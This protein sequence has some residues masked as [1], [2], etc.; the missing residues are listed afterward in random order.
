MKIEHKTRAGVPV[1][2]CTL[3]QV[4][5]A[6]DF[7]SC[8]RDVGVELKIVGAERGRPFDKVPHFRLLRG[9]SG[10]AFPEV[11][12]AYAVLFGEVADHLEGNEPLDYQI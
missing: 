11:M 12:R 9:D 8:G 4:F 2:R 7:L 1:I 10:M 6:D 5:P 3:P